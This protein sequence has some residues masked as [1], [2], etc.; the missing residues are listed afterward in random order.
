MINCHTKQKVKSGRSKKIGR[1]FYLNINLQWYGVVPSFIVVNGGRCIWFPWSQTHNSSFISIA[2]L[3][4]MAWDVNIFYVHLPD[5]TMISNYCRTVHSINLKH[6]ASMA[7][8]FY[9]LLQPIKYLI[10]MV[11]HLPDPSMI[12]YMTFL[13]LN[14]YTF[15]I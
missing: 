15:A 11:C 8:K 10:E 2:N 7:N 3:C 13:S 12:F 5:P 1:T 6:Y 14:V 9:Q 4:S